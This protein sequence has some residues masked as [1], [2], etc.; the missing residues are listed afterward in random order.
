[1]SSNQPCVWHRRP[2]RFAAR[3]ALVRILCERLYPHYDLAVITNDIY[4]RED[5]ELPACA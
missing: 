3:R 1:M 2:G 4:T 5:A